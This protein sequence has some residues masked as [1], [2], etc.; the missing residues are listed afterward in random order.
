LA[1]RAG[2]DFEPHDLQLVGEN[3]VMTTV[4]ALLNAGLIEVESE[5]VVDGGQII[6][7]EA[8]GDPSTSDDDLKRYWFVMTPTGWA[9]WEAGADELGAYME[10]HPFEL[11]G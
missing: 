10:A 3:I 2:G 7:R 11:K 8:L 1:P 9:A 6:H 4:R 5:Y